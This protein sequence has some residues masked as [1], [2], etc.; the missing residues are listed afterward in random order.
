MRE[1][2]TTIGGGRG[3]DLEELIVASIDALTGLDAVGAESL[4]E[5][6]SDLLED[7]Q[8]GINLPC[9]PAAWAQACSQH[10]VLGHL[11]AATGDR[12]AML[13]RLSAP[14]LAFAAYGTAS[15]SGT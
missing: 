8:A 2:G 14:K 5:L 9:S 1:C 6:F 15:R 7:R 4:A 11:L 10:W 13:R 12:L 3:Y